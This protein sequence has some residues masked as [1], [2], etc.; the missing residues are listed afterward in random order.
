MEIENK[1][2]LA[3]RLKLRIPSAKGPLM[4][5]DLWDLPMTTKVPKGV[6]LD[7]IAVALYNKR[8]AETQTSFVE[9]DVTEKDAETALQFDL[10]VHV[11]RVRKAEGRAKAE[12]V[13]RKQKVAELDELIQEKVKDEY[14]QLS[15]E[16]L[17]EMRRDISGK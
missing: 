16:Q 5:E 11:I 2:E 12:A 7:N 4:L 13:A 9:E 6:S 1:F 17:L 10:V 3:T 14:K 15:L 8:Q